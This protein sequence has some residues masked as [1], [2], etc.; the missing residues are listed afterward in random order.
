MTNADHFRALL[1]AGLTAEDVRDA[2]ADYGADVGLTKA[3]NAAQDIRRAVSDGYRTVRLSD[4]M[5]PLSRPDR[6]KQWAVRVQIWRGDA[7]QSD[8]AAHLGET[9]QG[10]VGVRGGTTL[11]GLPAVAEFIA[12]RVT[13]HAPDIALADALGVVQ[14]SIPSWRQSLYKYGSTA[15]RLDVGDERLVAYIVS[16]EENPK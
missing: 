11:L 7:L 5:A 12:G 8:S 9:I 14:A 1:G 4:L 13:A 2:I 3:R 15:Y 16:A 10:W 6:A